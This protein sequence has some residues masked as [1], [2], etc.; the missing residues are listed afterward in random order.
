MIN[1]NEKFDIE[2]VLDSLSKKRPVFHSEAD[3]QCA[4]AWEIHEMYSDFNIRLEKKEEIYGK[5]IYPDI[6]IFKKDRIYILELKYKTRELKITMPKEEYHLKNQ[7]AHDINRYDFCKDIERLEKMVE[8]YEK[9]NY[10]CTGFA[11]FLTN[12]S[13]YWVSPETEK[14]NTFDKEFRIHEGRIL[15]GILRW[16]EGASSGTTRGREDPINLSGMYCLR[17]K[18]YSNLNEKTNGEFRYLLVEVKHVNSV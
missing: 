3:F 7:G 2:N 16:K 13:Q 1:E 17:W 6:F 18:Y 4:L 11:I 15:R 14:P 10:I 8:K 9:S 5:E 12:D